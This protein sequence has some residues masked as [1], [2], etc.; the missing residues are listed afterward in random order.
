[1][2]IETYLRL[3][4][5][6][7]ETYLLERINP[8]SIAHVSENMGIIIYS[9]YLVLT[10]N[11]HNMVYCVFLNNINFL[12]CHFS[13]IFCEQIFLKSRYWLPLLQ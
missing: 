2:P 5:I 1:M 8:H 6:Y 12:N 10:L 11:L 13:R 3:T 9:I 7:R 4:E